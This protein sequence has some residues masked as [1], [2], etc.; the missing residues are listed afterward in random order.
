MTRGSTRNDR[1][2]DIKEHLKQWDC[3]DLKSTAMIL[4]LMEKLG[5]EVNNWKVVMHK[6]G[7]KK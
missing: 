3:L 4:D 6:H 5:H 7:Q 2:F 1:E